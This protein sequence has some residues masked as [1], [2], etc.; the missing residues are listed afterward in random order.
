MFTGTDGVLAAPAA[1]GTHSGALGGHIP[2]FIG[3]AGSMG[4]L[5]AA[6]LGA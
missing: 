5:A 4:L 6:L 1:T 3:L 2:N